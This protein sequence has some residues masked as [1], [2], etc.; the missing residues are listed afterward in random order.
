MIRNVFRT[1]RSL[2]PSKA[3]GCDKIIPNLL[4]NFAL[5]PYQ[6]LHNLF[7]SQSYLPSKWRTHLI[8]PFHAITVKRT[9]FTK[10]TKKSSRYSAEP[11]GLFLV[12][13]L[14]YFSSIPMKK[15]HGKPLEKDEVAVEVK[16]ITQTSSFE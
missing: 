5:A 13:A 12:Y 15:V 6:P 14:I 8:K 7:S 1:L 4:K 16:A 9:A 11:S 2:D 3:M 10:I